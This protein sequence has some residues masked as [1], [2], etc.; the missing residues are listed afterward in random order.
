MNK[1]SAL[2]SSSAH[3]RINHHVF[4]TGECIVNEYDAMPYIPTDFGCTASTSNVCRNKD[5]AGFRLGDSVQYLKSAA[6]CKLNV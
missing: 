3:N 1:Y 2:I 6:V 4:Q 5:H